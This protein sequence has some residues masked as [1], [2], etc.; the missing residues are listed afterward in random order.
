[1][2]LSP[3]RRPRA[4]L[5]AS[6][7]TAALAAPA[8]A[9]TV[10]PAQADDLAKQLRGW[11][12]GLVDNRLPI[13]PDA[14]RVAPAGANYRISVP[15]PLPLLDM[16]DASGGKLD[17]LFSLDVAPIDGGK[18]RIVGMAVPAS[19]RL[20]RDGSAMLG[21]L[22]GAGG[23][24]AR[25]GQTPAGPELEMKV[26]AQTASGVFDPS[27][28][29][30]SRLEYKVEGLTYSARNLTGKAEN[31]AVA[32]DTYLTTLT[33]RPNGGGLDIMVN[34]ALDG[35]RQTGEDRELGPYRVAMR[36][37]TGQYELGGLMTGQLTGIIRT[38]VN[39]GMDS[40]AALAAPGAPEEKRVK[41]EAAAREGARKIIGL[42]TGM[43]RGL[44]TQAVAEGIDIEIMGQKG[45]AGKFLIGWGGEAPAEKLKAFLE[46]GLDGL[47]VEALPPQYQDLLPRSIAFRPSVGNID[48]KALTDLAREAAADGADSAALE[49][50]LQT[51]LTSTGIEV[52]LDRLRIDLGIAQL[53]AKMAATIVGPMQAKGEGEI[54]ITGYDALMEK[55]SK[56]PEGAQALPVL[57]LL[58]GLSKTEGN[59]KV[60][61][62]ALTPDNKMTVNGMDISK[63]AGN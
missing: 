10:T 33:T 16:Q 11:L 27:Q 6:V 17:S 7:L 22:T 26:R 45:G 32:V 21:G 37:I 1:M 20:S 8:G 42:L 62:L 25:P 54:G 43:L 18:W 59:R 31:A 50:K 30:E 53:D 36:R 24:A 29:S 47:K 3:R 56:L 9:Q 23:G 46:F 38:A 51:L 40:Q 48:V 19:L 14:L 63:I 35:Y 15:L 55:V 12:S 57:A 52:G 44:S 4:A 28:A 49:R 13:P 2:F 39:L 60:W 58:G 5:L 34:L 61:R 41:G